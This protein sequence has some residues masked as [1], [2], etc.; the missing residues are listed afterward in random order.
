MEK[1]KSNTQNCF[2]IKRIAK[3]MECM[4]FQY[5]F[6]GFGRMVGWFIWNLVTIQYLCLCVDCCWNQDWHANSKRRHRS[7]P[8]RMKF[9][10]YADNDDDDG[11]DNNDCRRVRENEE[12]NMENF[13]N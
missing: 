5:L 12:T 2:E 3:L 11:D 13:D 4:R 10:E 8:E 9:I 6:S 7:T 1:K